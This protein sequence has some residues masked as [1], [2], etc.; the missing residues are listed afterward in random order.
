MITG[1]YT[2][3][4][5]KHTFLIFDSLDED[6]TDEVKSIRSTKRREYFEHILESKDHISP[7]KVVLWRLK[8]LYEQDFLDVIRSH[9]S[10]KQVST[11]QS[12]E[13]PQK[14]ELMSINILKQ[15]VSSEKCE[16]AKILCSVPQEDVIEVFI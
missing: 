7:T 6:Q 5:I 1:R 16:T 10:K 9:T 11:K 14:L 12:F 4:S 15:D 8:L 2:I 13:D 3:P